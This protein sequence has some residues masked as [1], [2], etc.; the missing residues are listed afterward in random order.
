M[1]FGCHQVLFKMDANGNGVLIERDRLYLSLG[2]RPEN[3]DEEKY[4]GHLL[5][6]VSSFNDNFYY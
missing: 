2:G 5:L 1:A 6:R 3:Y 4:D